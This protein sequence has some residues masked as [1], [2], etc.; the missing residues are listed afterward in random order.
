MGPYIENHNMFNER[1]NVSFA[2][3]IDKDHIYIDVWERG[4]GITKACGSAACATVVAAASLGITNRNA[5]VSFSGGDLNISWKND[6]NIV[7][8]GPYEL[9]EILNIDLSDL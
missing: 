7:M 4:T 1:V 2:E 8:T 9:N 6:N 5:K 3:L